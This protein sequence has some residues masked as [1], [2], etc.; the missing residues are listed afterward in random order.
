MYFCISNI[1]FILK[2]MKYYFFLLLPALLLLW[3]CPNPPTEP[4]ATGTLELNFTPYW[5]GS[6]LEFGVAQ[7]AYF[8]RVVTLDSF[9]FY[10]SNIRAVKNDNTEVKVSDIVLF[11]FLKAGKKA[12]GSGVFESFTLKV[13][14]Y[15]GLIF[16]IGVSP[17]LNH[18]NAANYNP[19]SP[20]HI[21][22]DM[23]W[24][25]T[26]GYTFVFLKGKT[27]SIGTQFPISYRVGLD[28][29]LTPLNYTTQAKD[30][31][32]I[33]KNTETQFI[34]QIDLREILAGIDVAKNPIIDARPKNSAG[35]V[36]S[37]QLLDNLKN[38][39][40]FKEP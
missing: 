8:G 35:Y 1:L 26:D 24:N 39:S 7:N 2:M 17:T 27:D 28:D 20:L 14:N 34:L 30:A 21:S 11:D 29:L 32:S 6:A 10:V 37:Q 31:F 5:N 19:D 23:F 36:L 33:T 38:K 3:G 18:T 12:H 9:Q 15:K 40:L 16:D 13:G 4:D 22:K 25:E